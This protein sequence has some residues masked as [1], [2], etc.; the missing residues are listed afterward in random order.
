V[1]HGVVTLSVVVARIAIGGVRRDR[2]LH[3]GIGHCVGAMTDGHARCWRRD[4]GPY[5]SDDA[6]DD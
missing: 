4:K 3:V 5:R 2:D 6:A 1:L